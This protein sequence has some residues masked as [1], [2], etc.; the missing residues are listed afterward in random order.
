MN[1]TPPFARLIKG[2]LRWTPFFYIG[3]QQETRIARGEWVFGTGTRN[4]L[5]LSKSRQTDLERPDGYTRVETPG[6]LIRA[7]HARTRQS[8]STAEFLVSV[9]FNLDPA[10]QKRT[11]VVCALHRRTFD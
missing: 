8:F 5:G 2:P 4:T 7:I 9:T 3:P 6:Y 1:L 11:I 10:H